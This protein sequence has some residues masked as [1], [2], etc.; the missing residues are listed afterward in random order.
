VAVLDLTGLGQN[1]TSEQW[2][3]GLLERVG[4]QLNLEEPLDR[5][6]ME[7][8]DLG[9]L[10]RWMGAVREIVLRHCPSQLVV[11]IDEIDVVR[12]LGFSADELFAGIRELYNRRTEDSDLNRLTFCLLGVAAPSDLIRETRTTPFNVGQR[13]ELSDFTEEEAAPLAQGLSADP[14]IAHRLLRRVLYWSNGHPYLTQRLC[15][16]IAEGNANHPSAVDRLCADL[17]FSQRA[18]HR[19]DNLLF[20]RE[21]LLRSEVDTPSLLTLYGKV[22]SGKRVPDDE[23]NP[24]VTVLRLAGITRVEGRRLKVHNRIYA[25]VFDDRWVTSNLPGAELRR[26]RTAFLRG[27]K[28]ASAFAIPLLIAVSIYGFFNIYRIRTTIPPPA[29]KAPEP[30]VF[31]ASFTRPGSFNVEAGALLVRVGEDDALV[32]I[33]NH[34]YGRTGGNGL[35]QVPILQQGTY[36]IRVEKPGYQTVSQPALIVANKETQLAF[37][38]QRQVLLGTTIIVQHGIVGANVLLDGVQLGQLQKDGTFSADVRPG[39]HSLQLSKTGYLTKEINQQ[40]APGE[41]IL[42][43]GQLKPD[44]E[45]QEWAALVG[46]RDAAQLQ[47][48]LRQY[49]EGR[50]SEA[51]RKRVEELEWNSVKDSSDLTAL[52]SFLKKYPRGEFVQFA[53]E[54]VAQLQKE[55][56]D[57]SFA[58]QSKDPNAIQAFIR[59]HPRGQYVEE[60]RAELRKLESSR[61]AAGSLA[62]A[63]AAADEMSLRTVIDRYVEAYEKRSVDAVRQIWP[64]IDSKRYGEFKQSFGS[65][66]SISINLVIDQVTIA[67]DRTKATVTSS[68]SQRYTPKNGK[69]QMS[70]DRIVFQLSKTNGVWSINDVQ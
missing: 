10:Q 15:L 24:L 7:H 49:P 37:K 46:S 52:D 13:I 18:R 3:N 14:K 36:T 40:F 69:E 1:L 70:Q 48:F 16:S 59:N 54:L 8:R 29:F 5:F 17:F 12:S 61:A 23:T 31:W 41:R 39:D 42:L 65:A 44:T 9:P 68:V 63:P 4:Q 20:V 2:Y 55:A 66:K 27:L 19:D 6:W 58:R 22:W 51:A 43:D 53:R 11:F 45:A 64:T 47:V 34:E 26:Q 62:A 60:A 38:L 33:N 21:R 35:L 50:F 57:W 32:F 25:R 28:V 56:S 67:P 30:P